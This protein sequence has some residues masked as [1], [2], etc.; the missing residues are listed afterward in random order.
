MI[1]HL[2]Q[3]SNNLYT[4]I[5]LPVTGKEE[6]DIYISVMDFFWEKLKI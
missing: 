1:T 3:T 6:N 5:C 2:K 4:P